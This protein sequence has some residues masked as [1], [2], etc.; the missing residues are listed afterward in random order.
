MFLLSP[1]LPLHSAAC[2]KKI[3]YCMPVVAGA[4]LW[5]AGQHE[6]LLMKVLVPVNSKTS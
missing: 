5:G 2:K 6:T 4:K 1:P 3:R